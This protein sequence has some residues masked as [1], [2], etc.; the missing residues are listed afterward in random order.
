M[1]A[2]PIAL[3]VQQPGGL[4]PATSYG[5]AGGDAASAWQAVGAMG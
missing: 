3:P 2:P 5:P 4:L 1:Q